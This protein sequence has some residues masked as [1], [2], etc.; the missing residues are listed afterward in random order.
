MT[1]SQ[2]ISH[3]QGKKRN[4]RNWASDSRSIFLIVHIVQTKIFLKFE[5]VIFLGKMINC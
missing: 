3:T 4:D 5:K 2:S 1:S